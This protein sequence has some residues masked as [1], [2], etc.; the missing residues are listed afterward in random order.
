MAHILIID[1][2]D[3]FRKMVRYMLEK[4]GYD[5]FEASDGNKG[6]KIYQ[7]QEIDLVITDIFMPD[8]E[9]IETIIELRRDNPDIKIIAVSG[10]GWKG[11]FDAL[12]IAEAFGVQ[13]AFEKPFERKEIIDTIK[14]LLNP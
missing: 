10:G 3:G 7:D 6:I 8:K 14:E 4:E 9:G 2:D 1:D 5:V 11:D 12:K 13:K